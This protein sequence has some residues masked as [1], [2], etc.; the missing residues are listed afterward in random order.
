MAAINEASGVGVKG[1]R[2]AATV[3]I[4]LAIMLAGLGWYTS[5]TEAPPLDAGIESMQPSAPP[6]PL[7]YPVLVA[8]RELS[9]GERPSDLPDALRLAYFPTPL[10]GS[11]AELA[12]VPD[13]RL[14]RPLGEGDVLRPGGFVGGG[15]LADVVP[16]GF[17]AVGV[18]I[19]AVIG[20]GGFVAPGDRVDVLFFAETDDGNGQR[21]RLARRLFSD[22][23]VLG[24]GERLVGG[25]RQE[26]SGS[27][28]TAVLAMPETQTARLLLAEATGRL[29]LAVVGNQEAALGESFDDGL[30][31]ALGQSVLP[32]SLGQSLSQ[33]G[34]SVSFDELTGIERQPPRPAA[35]ASRAQ[36]YQVVQHVG[37]RSR[38]VSLP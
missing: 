28:R 17:R 27:E 26:D 24:V 15:A 22:V 25:D 31:F 7:G 10:D 12:Q 36:G 9:A 21:H 32:V 16:P 14:A 30:R 18:G 37:A 29:R 35:Q 11:F 4:L 38:V 23:S 20:G 3:L 6:E 8:A 2:V 34:N 33:P 1:L 19:D 13:A 5:S